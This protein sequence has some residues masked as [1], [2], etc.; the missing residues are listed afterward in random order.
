MTMAISAS[1]PNGD[2][3][4]SSIQTS[5]LLSTAGISMR[6]DVFEFHQAAVSS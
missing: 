4:G 3:W 6:S 1:D 5:L 2:R